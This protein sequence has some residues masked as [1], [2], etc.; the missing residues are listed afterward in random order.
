M[1]SKAIWVILTQGITF[2]LNILTV[3]LSPGAINNSN[4]IS[5]KLLKT[6][7]A[8]EVERSANI[9]IFKI[10]LKVSF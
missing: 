7:I 4:Y 2:A 5:L 9:Y 1:K 8:K 10:C 3:S 6:S